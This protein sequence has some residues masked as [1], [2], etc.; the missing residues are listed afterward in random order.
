MPQKKENDKRRNVQKK[1]QKLQFRRNKKINTKRRKEHEPKQKKK[2]NSKQ[3]R[4]EKKRNINE[5]VNQYRKTCFQ[6]QLVQKKTQCVRAVYLLFT[7]IKASHLDLVILC[8]E[9]A[10]SVSSILCRRDEHRPDSAL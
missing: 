10:G 2:L 3:Q 5:I 1:E 7:D 8:F 6:D 4:K 9:S